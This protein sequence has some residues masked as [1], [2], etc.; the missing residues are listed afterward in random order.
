MCQATNVASLASVVQGYLNMAEKRTD[1]AK[2]ESQDSVQE[3]RLLHP[4]TIAVFL[5]LRCNSSGGRF[6]EFG[7]T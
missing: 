7:H 1:S 4:V 5:M 2:Q 6:G 3:V